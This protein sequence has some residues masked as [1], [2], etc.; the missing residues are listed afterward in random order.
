MKKLIKY[1]FIAFVSC[2]YSCLE[3]RDE[4]WEKRV[5]VVENVYLRGGRSST[6]VAECDDGSYWCTKELDKFRKGYKVHYISNTQYGA[7]RLKLIKV[8]RQ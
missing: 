2:F 6:I 5:G 1:G 7:D 4:F 8:C 3:K